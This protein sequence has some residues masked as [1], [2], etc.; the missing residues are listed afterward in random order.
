MAIGS[1]LIFDGL[2]WPAARIVGSSS[3]VFKTYPYDAEDKPPSRPL[4]T[5]SA[6]G[7][8]RRWSATRPEGFWRDFTELDLANAEAVAAFV[9]RR[10]DPV[11]M[12]GAST[13]SHT[14]YWWRLQTCLMTA[15]QAWEPE[16]AA[17][18]S[19][20]TTDRGRLQ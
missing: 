10:G 15:V 16:D 13:E 6:S 1:T 14:G 8:G 3:M 18:V 12:L 20:V 11:G 17:G 7:R 4:F 19:R 2:A 5:L 9:R